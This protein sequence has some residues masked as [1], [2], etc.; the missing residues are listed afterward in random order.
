MGGLFNSKMSSI[1]QRFSIVGLMFV[2]CA[3][4]AQVPGSRNMSA[5]TTNQTICVPE[6]LPEIESISLLG[7]PT[8]LP[9]YSFYADR[10]GRLVHQSIKP[11]M[12]KN[13]GFIEE[14]LILRQHVELFNRL[15]EHLHP[16]DFLTYHE[17]RENG[18]PDELR[19]GFVITFSNGSKILASKW[20]SDKV[21]ALDQLQNEVELTIKEMRKVQQPVKMPYDCKDLGAYFRILEAN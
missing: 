20:V 6:K 1:L 16:I 19:L 10:K 15:V 11:D 3:L 14:R 13:Y 9:G 2:V 21:P 12:E 8:I 17:G 4:C 7:P 5:S 18:I